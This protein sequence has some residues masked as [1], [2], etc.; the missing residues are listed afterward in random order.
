VDLVG[1]AGLLHYFWTLPYII[2]VIS[3]KLTQEPCSS[4]S[5]LKIGNT[6]HYIILGE[7]SCRYD[8]E[9][10]QARNADILKEA[11]STACISD[12]DADVN[13]D[14]SK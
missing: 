9:S 6:V 12:S 13:E 11:V 8:S 2:G 14:L 3:Q 10:T 1:K 5:T 7:L 4:T